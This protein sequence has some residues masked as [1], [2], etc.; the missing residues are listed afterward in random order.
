M[1]EIML[2]HAFGATIRGLGLLAFVTI[3]FNKL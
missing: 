1:F 2:Y 3:M